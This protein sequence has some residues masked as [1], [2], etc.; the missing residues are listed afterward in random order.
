MVGKGRQTAYW[1]GMMT[2]IVAVPVA[3]LHIAEAKPPRN[4]SHVQLDGNPVVRSRGT[5]KTLPTPAGCPEY[6]KERP[7]HSF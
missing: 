5:E 6:G 7:G 4:V 1:D 3:L 2:G